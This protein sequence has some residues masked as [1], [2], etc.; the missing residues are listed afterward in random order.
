MC[1]DDLA[2]NVLS[3]TDHLKQDWLKQLK[4]CTTCSL[5]R[6]HYLGRR[7]MLLP[8]KLWLLKTEPHS[9]LFVLTAATLT[10]VSK[11][12]DSYKKKLKCQLWF[13]EKVLDHFNSNGLRCLA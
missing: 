2:K 13:A 9:F 10:P 6:S 5:L 8:N 11:K 1:S 4:N 3:G 7:A 12:S